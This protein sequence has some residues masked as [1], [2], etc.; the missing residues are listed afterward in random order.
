MTETFILHLSTIRDKPL[1]AP[2]AVTMFL[3]AVSYLS[4]SISFAHS[5]KELRMG[6]VLL[7]ITRPDGLMT[8]TLAF[9]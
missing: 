8:S 9:I 7:L 2:A 5:H 3:S 1:E 6:L 4:G